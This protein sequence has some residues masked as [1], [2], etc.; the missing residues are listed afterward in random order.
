MDWHQ[1]KARV[2]ELAHDLS[3]GGPG[4][5]EAGKLLLRTT[6]LAVAG[7]GLADAVRT[8][9]QETTEDEAT[10]AAVAEALDA[11]DATEEVAE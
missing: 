6:A 11:W 10:L 8:H 3:L 7:K 9:L 5:V 1:L 4:E 2:A